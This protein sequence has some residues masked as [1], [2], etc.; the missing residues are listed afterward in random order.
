ME[1]GHGGFDTVRQGDALILQAMGHW[2]VAS[3]AVLDSGLRGIE[4][5]GAR[6]VH[7]DLGHIEGLDTVGAWLLLRTCRAF[8]K[9]GV[10]ASIENVPEVF[11]PLLDQVAKNEPSPRPAARRPF[12]HT[13]L[14]GVQFVGEAAVE[15]IVTAR[16]LLNFFGLV[17]VTILRIWWQPSRL[18]VASLVAQ[19]QRTGVSALPII[20]LLSFLIGIV[21][22]FQGADQLRRF[23]AEI[24]A[25]NLLGIGVLRELG[26][27]LTAV[28]VAGRSGSAFT[29]EIG[30]MQVNEEIDAMRTLGLD[31]IEILVLPRLFGLVLALPLLTFYGDVMAL[32]GGALMSWS[33]LGIPPAAF[34]RQLH[35]AVVGWTLWL[36]LVKAPFFAVTIALVGCHAGLRVSRSAESVGRL[37]TLSVVQSIFLVIVIDALFSILFSA[38]HV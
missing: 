36:G 9:R 10:A 3:A 8:E 30:A 34:L 22:T 24:F 18:R 7:F 5:A 16:E 11:G 27:L 23:G 32:L 1:P 2:L 12:H 4:A 19:M 31:P 15:F 38:L 17:C 21:L 20:G 25:V 26:V 13:I 14:E 28:I 35:D 29:A 33:A 6:S 37:T